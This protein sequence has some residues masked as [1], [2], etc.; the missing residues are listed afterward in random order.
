VE[1]WSRGAVEPWSRGAVEPWSRGAVEPWSRG[2]VE[3]ICG[4]SLTTA[5]GEIGMCGE[6]QAD[7]FRSGFFLQ[8]HSA[9][10]V[11]IEPTKEQLGDF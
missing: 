11:G 5:R 1:P 6:R 8:A 2:A 4:R 9:P 3:F 10:G 7:S